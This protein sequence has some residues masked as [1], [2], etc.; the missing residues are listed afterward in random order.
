MIYLE[1]RLNTVRNNGEGILSLSLAPNGTHDFSDVLSSA[2][3]LVAAGLDQLLLITYDPDVMILSDLAPAEQEYVIRGKRNG[4]YK[5][6]AFDNITAIRRQYPDLPLIMTPMLGDLL[7]YGMERFVKKAAACG[8]NGWDTCN[9]RAVTDPV[10]F[11][12]LAEQEGMG[13]I[14]AI[15]A[16]GV[17]LQN[18]EQKELFEKTVLASSGELFLVPAVPGSSDGISGKTIK[19]YVD[20]IREIQARA[21]RH[22]PIIGIGGIT[23]VQDVYEVVRVAG[24]DGVHFSSAYMKKKFRGDSLESIRKWLAEAKTAMR[25]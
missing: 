8:V 23:T 21:N 3:Y 14:C 15:S 12:R 9:Y 17:D 7:S 22:F 16:G 25:K 18:P 1:Q 6:M 10:G 4:C 13:F 5:D 19:P 11:R 20:L 24:A 2:E